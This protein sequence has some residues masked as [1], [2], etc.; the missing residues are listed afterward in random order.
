MTKHSS[1]SIGCWGCD[2][3]MR[4]YSSLVNHLESGKCPKLADPALLMR[5]LGKWWYSPLYMDLDMHASIRTG[6][7]DIHEVQHW[8]TAGIIHPFVC[9][10]EEC[11][12]VFGRLSSLVLH[13]ESKACGW[14]VDR[15]NMPGLEKELKLTCL[16]RDSATG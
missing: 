7:V 1:V 13:C 15:L 12:K 14:N 5:C 4:T 16:R 9:R 2:A 8:S 10:D 3:P 6:R 11:G